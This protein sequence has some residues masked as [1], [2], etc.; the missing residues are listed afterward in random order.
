MQVDPPPLFSPEGE[1]GMGGH[2]R[3]TTATTTTT[4]TITTTQTGILLLLSLLLLSPSSQAWVLHPRYR[5]SG[6]STA[7]TKRAL[8][9]RR[10][11]V[12]TDGSTK[13]AESEYNR[14]VRVEKEVAT[15]YSK[16]DSKGEGREGGGREG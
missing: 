3:R 9:T 2:M 4:T 16:G 12:G 7:A 8:D 10:A 14:S 1:R 11:A 6:G 13:E 5:S 15:R